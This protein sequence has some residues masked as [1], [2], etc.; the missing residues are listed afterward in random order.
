MGIRDKTLAIINSM[1]RSKRSKMHQQKAVQA[2]C[3]ACSHIHLY[4]VYLYICMCICMFVYYIFKCITCL[5]GFFSYMYL[6]CTCISNL[7]LLQRQIVPRPLPFGL[8]TQAPSLP[9][10][11]SPTPLPTQPP[12]LPIPSTTALQQVHVQVYCTH[13][14]T[15]TV[16]EMCTCPYT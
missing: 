4:H 12:S 10:T 8:P 5:S 15:C 6:Q 3:I 1:K 13:A 7:V 14:H 9:P 2:V 16:H 11:Q